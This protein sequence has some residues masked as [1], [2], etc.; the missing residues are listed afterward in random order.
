[1]PAHPACRPAEGRDAG[2]LQQLLGMLAAEGFK[3]PFPLEDLPA[4]LQDITVIEREGQVGGA[5]WRVGGWPGL[6]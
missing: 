6:R 2:G 1:M 4:R 5:G 3:L